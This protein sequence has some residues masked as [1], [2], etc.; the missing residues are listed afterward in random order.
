M[1]IIELIKQLLPILTVIAQAIIIGLLILLVYSYFAKKPTLPGFASRHAIFSALVV[2]TIATLGSLFYSEVAGFELC[3]LCW[4]QRILMYPQVLLLAMAF[5]K[6]DK[7][8]SDYILPFSAIGAFVA[9]YHYF[10]QIEILPPPSCSVV[11]FSISCSQ[12][13]FMHFGYITIPMMAFTA[14][15]LITLFMVVQKVYS[16]RVK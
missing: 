12:R 6:N 2:A 11:G 8:I 3:K 5:W 14:F 16:Y 10:L 15:V 7:G 13:F 9:G 1:E 4:F